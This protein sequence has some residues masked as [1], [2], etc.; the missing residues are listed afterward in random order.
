[1]T[2]QT[3]E[4][5][6]AKPA[7]PCPGRAIAACSIGV[8]G[9]RVMVLLSVLLFCGCRYTDAVN[10]IGGAGLQKLFLLNSLQQTAGT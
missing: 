10:S 4:M 5:N 9:H 8:C 1:M 7:G 3:A 6:V 2:L